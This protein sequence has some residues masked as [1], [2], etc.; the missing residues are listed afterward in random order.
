LIEL[1][2]VTARL[3]KSEDKRFHDDCK[4]AWGSPFGI[5]FSV[6]HQYP[7]ATHLVRLLCVRRQRPRR[8]RPAEK[9][10]TRT[11]SCNPPPKAEVAAGYK[12]DMADSRADRGGALRVLLLPLLVAANCSPCVSNRSFC[13][14]FGRRKNLAAHR[15]SNLL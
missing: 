2:P 15:F 6:D 7:E 9:R 14:A 10:D 12:A 5:V 3:G 11:V 8:R 4:L 1:H 13:G